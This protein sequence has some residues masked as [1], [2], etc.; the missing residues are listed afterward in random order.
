M[1]APAGG[2]AG[3]PQRDGGA[4]S[5][6][7][8]T[9]QHR[10]ADI[11]HRAGR[12]ADGR[13]GGGLERDLEQLV[14][15]EGQ[16][17]VQRDIER[18]VGLYQTQRDRPAPVVGLG[19]ELQRAIGRRG[20]RAERNQ[21]QAARAARTRAGPAW[22]PAA[23]SRPSLRRQYRARAPANATIRACRWQAWR[24]MVGL[25]G[26]SWIGANPE[27]AQTL[28]TSGANGCSQAEVF[29]RPTCLRRPGGSGWPP[30]A[31]GTATRRGSPES[32]RSARPCAWP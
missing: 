10:A 30:P 13:S 5:R 29:I 1:Q 9:H 7:G 19:P 15:L 12:A 18:L 32:P 20:L 23:A 8:L 6:G 3:V 24:I 16:Q 22:R 25:L 28:H 14:V 2:P 31:G 26:V 4:V 27:A 11:E 17:A 21:F